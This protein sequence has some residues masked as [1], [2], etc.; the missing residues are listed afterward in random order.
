[1][2]A[3]VLCAGL[4]TRLR[5]LTDERPKPLVPVLGRPLASYALARLAG[6]GVRHVVCN[7]H[8]LGAQVR[9]ALEP[10]AQRAN[11]AL[12]TVH[13][14]TLL[15]TGGAL[16]NALPRFG[17]EP[18]YVC[19]GDVLA[20]PDLRALRALHERTGARMTLVLREDPRAEKLGAIDVDE[21]GRVRRILGEGPAPAEP[22]KRCI[23]T[24]VYLVAGD[25]GD[26][27]PDNGCVVR[28][29]LRR[30]LARGDTVSGLLDD[31]PWFDLGTPETYVGVQ[32]GLLDGSIAFPG[33][34][35]PF[36]AR[37]LDPTARVGDDVRLGRYLSVGAGAV[38]AGRGEVRD[39][40]LWDGARVTAPFEGAV[41]TAEGRVVRVGNTA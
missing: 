10:Y 9:P 32:R 17:G 30:L 19:N 20:A 18:F 11:L 23:F 36:E 34:E 29:T 2:R 22:F 16:K 38:L 1:M 35:P 12:E 28:H 13:E 21:A 8:H 31:G 40:V 24:G 37:W 33:V 25:L 6:A 39:A 14:E 26:D 4:G 7:T 3:M 5:P 41:V 15:G 27:L